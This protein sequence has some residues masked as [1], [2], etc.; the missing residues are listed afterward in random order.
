ME[1]LQN[2]ETCWRPK[3]I[4]QN[5]SLLEVQNVFD[6]YNLRG[7]LLP[8]LG[9]QDTVMWELPDEE[10]KMSLVITIWEDL[11]APTK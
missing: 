4:W 9:G 2:R 7:F 11:P 10:L 8:L 3:C 5:Y 1:K 6:N